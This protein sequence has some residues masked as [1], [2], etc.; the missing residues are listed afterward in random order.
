MARRRREAHSTAKLTILAAH[1]RC[2][3]TACKIE[4]ILVND[5]CDKPFNK[6]NDSIDVSSYKWNLKPLLSK[7]K[8][9]CAPQHHLMVIIRV[10]MY[11]FVKQFLVYKNNKKK[12]PFGVVC[13]DWLWT[14]ISTLLI[15]CFI[16]LIY[17]RY[18]Y[19]KNIKKMEI[20]KEKSDTYGLERENSTVVLR[21]LLIYKYTLNP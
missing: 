21:L 20:W 14:A 19:R 1:I 5:G 16:I 12:E 2:I 17:A 8:L 4:I 9:M 7:L 11:R 18:K 6:A 13:M 10:N 3:L 15:K